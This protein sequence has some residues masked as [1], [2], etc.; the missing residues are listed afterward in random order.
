MSEDCL[1]IN[2]FF[3]NDTS[4]TYPTVV[5]LHGGNYT[6][7][8]N[9]LPEYRGE[10][11]LENEDVILI[12][13]P[14]TDWARSASCFL[15]DEK[16]PGNFAS[17]GPTAR[18]RLHPKSDPLFW[19]QQD[20]DHSDGRAGRN[21]SMI[22]D[23]YDAVVVTMNYR[24]GAFGFLSLD[25]KE[26]VAD[27]IESFGGNKNRI[28]LMGVEAGAVS[29][30]YHMARPKQNRFHQVVLM[31]GSPYMSY[32]LSDDIEEQTDVFQQ[33]FQRLEFPPIIDGD[34]IR[35]DPWTMD[36]ST[37][38]QV[39][40]IFGGAG[41]T[42]K[43]SRTPFYVFGNPSSPGPIVPDQQRRLSDAHHARHRSVCL[44]RPSILT[45]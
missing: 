3:P 11:L 19:R 25:N 9:S 4:N 41:P 30:G 28:T 36:P 2:V 29:I 33:L 16:L 40:M 34:F 44:E 10:Q 26:W 20:A 45:F 39:P 32:P 22:L 27:N 12:T 17:D 43:H 18:S 5:F 21:G 1:Y 24:L 6:S 42:W 38:M 15:D 14:T 23:H 13:G 35:L 8:A 31:T 7:G 37:L